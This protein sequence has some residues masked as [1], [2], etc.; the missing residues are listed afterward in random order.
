[1]GRQK[2]AVD[3]HVVLAQD[4]QKRFYGASDEELRA[5]AARNGVDYI[6]TRKA[7]ES[8]SRSLPIAFENGQYKVYSFAAKGTGG[9]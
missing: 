1:V 4:L 2:L 7:L 6:V 8:R 3:D 5:I 9:N